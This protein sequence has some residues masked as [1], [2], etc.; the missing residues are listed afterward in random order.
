MGDETSSGEAIGGAGLCLKK[1]D[2][3][4]KSVPY[5]LTKTIAEKMK[6]S[7]SYEDKILVDGAIQRL[8]AMRTSNGRLPYG[9]AAKV[10]KAFVEKGI[11]L[12]LNCIYK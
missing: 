1:H 11:P 7:Y 3:N 4:Y 12:T 6:T 10:A 9:A 8:V 5:W 2:Q